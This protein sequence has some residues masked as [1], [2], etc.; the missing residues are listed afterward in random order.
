[1]LFDA[2]RCTHNGTGGASTLT[3][4]GISGYPQITDVLGSS[5]TAFGW[6]T[7]AE[8]TDNT[9]ATLSKFERGIG[10]IALS[11]GVLTRSRVDVTWTSGGSYVR[12]GATAL[13][14][15]NTAAN[16][17]IL[18]GDSAGSVTAHMPGVFDFA[19]A[20]DI[21]QPINSLQIYSSGLG[22][23]TIVNG[24]RVWIP[25]F[26]RHNKP[27]SQVSVSCS[28]AAAAS[29]IRVGIYD[30]DPVHGG[31]GNL[32]SELTSG[33]QIATTATGYRSITLGTP[34]RMV[35]GWYWTC[36]QG[37]NSTVVIDRLDIQCNPGLSQQSQRDI[38]FFVKNATYGALPATGDTSA[39]S[40]YNRSGGGQPGV[41][42]Q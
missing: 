9:K 8:Y 35:P 27:I 38:V 37:N 36:L 21:W 33:S 11:S 19:G 31:P 2:V 40:V 22:S 24:D 13:T 18:F 42:F 6:Y 26:W 25:T 7:I 34:F 4:A 41:F 14:F 29:A 5:G 28:T 23:W 39:S 17:D 16:I 10:S 15:G 32:L 20:T 1:M 12:G 3:L 30:W